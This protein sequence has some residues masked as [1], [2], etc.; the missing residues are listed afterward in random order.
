MERGEDGCQGAQV[1][2]TDGE[3]EAKSKNRT[4]TEVE[5]WKTAETEGTYK[6]LGLTNSQRWGE[7]TGSNQE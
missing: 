6:K 4:E 1:V 5:D 2:A 7:R 3:T